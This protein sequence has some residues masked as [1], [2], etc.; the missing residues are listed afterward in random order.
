MGMS[1]HS[2]SQW[3]MPMSTLQAARGAAICS[4][5]PCKHLQHSACH[6]S[7]HLQLMPHLLHIHYQGFFVV[8][9]QAFRC[10]VWKVEHQHDATC[11]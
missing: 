7:V 1:G 5:V 8:L 9:V 11:T 3:G 6:L 4:S 2:I 10:R